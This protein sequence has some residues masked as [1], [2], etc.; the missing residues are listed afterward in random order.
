[1]MDKADEKSELDK[2]RAIISQLKEMHFYSKTNIEKLTEF[3]LQFD[4]QAKQKKM[5]K[6]VEELLAH[7]NAFH[8]A[9]ESLAADYEME[10]N[11]IENEAS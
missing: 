8:D 4:G 9:I 3:W 1:M 11:Q 10:C 6:R 2:A 5:A 7:Q